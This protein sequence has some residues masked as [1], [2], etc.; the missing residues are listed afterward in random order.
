MHVMRASAAGLCALCTTLTPAR[1]WLPSPPNHPGGGSG[2]AYPGPCVVLLL[3]TVFEMVMDLFLGNLK[4][5][6]TPTVN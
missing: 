1:P 4:I 2:S 5:L 6:S 3:V